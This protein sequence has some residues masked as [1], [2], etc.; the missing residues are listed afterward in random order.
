MGA[1]GH[2]LQGNLKH[3]RA[4]ACQRPAADP[5]T[6]VVVI[7]TDDL[8]HVFVGGEGDAI[9]LMERH[10]FQWRRDLGRSGVC[11]AALVVLGRDGLGLGKSDRGGVQGESGNLSGWNQPWRLV[12]SKGLLLL[13]GN[14]CVSACPP[15]R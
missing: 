7:D 15:E 11:G 4:V 6:V 2:L 14:R 13:P 1:A 3:G 10:G 8:V 9:T 5:A 12:P